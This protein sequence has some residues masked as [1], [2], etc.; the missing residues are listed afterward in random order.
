MT[1]QNYTCNYSQPASSANIKE[2]DV[3]QRKPPDHVIRIKQ[4]VE[5]A[6]RKTTREKIQEIAEE[7]GLSMG[8]LERVMGITTLSYSAFNRKK[9]RKTLKEKAAKSPDYDMLEIRMHGINLTP[10]TRAYI[11]KLVRVTCETRD[12]TPQSIMNNNGRRTSLHISE[13][14]AML[15]TA[16]SGK[17]RQV[18]SSKIMGIVPSTVNGHKER[19]KVYYEKSNKYRKDYRKILNGVKN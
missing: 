10:D 1:D 8:F 5:K 18:D 6:K 19:H 14:R 15:V 12:E 13:S 4:A 7:N 9:P 17:L 11:R 16:L 2:P 3:F